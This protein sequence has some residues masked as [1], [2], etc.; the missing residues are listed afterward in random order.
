MRALVSIDGIDVPDGVDCAVWDGDGPPPEDV[1]DVAFYVPPYGRAA[2]GL[3][4]LRRMPRLRVLQ[5]LSAGVD[6]VLAHVPDGVILCNARG[7]HDAS[8]A[9]LAVGLTLAAQRDLPQFHR[10]QLEGRWR[11]RRSQGLADATVLLVGYG[12]IGAAIERRLDGFE[13][14]ILR[15]ARRARDGVHDLGELPR[16]LPQADVVIVVVPLTDQTRG[17]VDAGFL[18]RMADGAL[19]VNVSRGPVLDTEALIGELGSG[20]LRAAL[21][22]TDPEP[23]P[24]RHPLW[25]APGL[26]LTPH[27]GGGTAAMLPRAR[28]LVSD[29]LRRFAA[30]EP[31]ANVITGSY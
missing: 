12:A 8:T 16:L 7:V 13:V 22:V 28:A 1:E 24:A 9:E 3:D 2:E 29:Q 20:R 31:L 10:A 6:T 21:D 17:L 11:P 18:A 5:S 14:D 15:V 23:L 25:T 26:I 4:L 19:L 30:G 27:V